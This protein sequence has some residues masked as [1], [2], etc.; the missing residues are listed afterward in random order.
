MEKNRKEYLNDVVDFAKGFK[1]NRSSRE[2]FVDFF[3]R[4]FLEQLKK[5]N[6]DKEETLVEINYSVVQALSQLEDEFVSKY[7]KEDNGIAARRMFNKIME[8]YFAKKK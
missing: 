2:D 4:E 7:H 1:L 8:H 3:K 6:A 5:D